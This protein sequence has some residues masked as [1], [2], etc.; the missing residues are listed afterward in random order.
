MQKKVRIAI[1]LHGLQ[2]SGDDVLFS[3]LSRFIDPDKISLTMLL[4]VDKGD[5]QLYE[6]DV[7]GHG[8][9]VIHL[10]DLDRGRILLWPW[11]LYRAFRQYGPFDGVHANMNMLS[12]LNLLAARL[13]GVPLR[14]SHAHS[15]AHMRDGSLFRKLYVRLM[16]ALI[17]RSA[18][19]R[20]ACSKS[21]GEYYYGSD[22]FVILDNGIDVEKFIYNA[23]KRLDKGKQDVRFL[24]VGRLAQDKNPLF[25]LDVFEAVHRK[26][27]AASLTWVGA[28]EMKSELQELVRK[29][30]LTDA[31]RF[32]GQRK[33]VSN[34]MQEADCFL[35]PSRYEAFGL[36]LLEAQATGL[37]CFASDTIPHKVDCGKCMFLSLEKS[38][39]EWAEEILRYIASEDRMKLD[40]DKLRKYD[41]R[42]MADRLTRLYQSG[43]PK[44]METE[45]IF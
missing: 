2:S 10:H 42:V 18:T 29:K 45:S 21:A 36:A 5:P 30:N 9:R 16:R 39:E 34:L 35:F 32:L 41:I 28:G 23:D 19:I 22:P 40:Q 8:V 14:I 33:N 11:T 26:L 24:T 20:L 17:H 25:L 4:A 13:A 27:P 12:G 31:V 6:E 37:D 38:P 1:I 43:D 15:P 44:S 3:Y 7:A